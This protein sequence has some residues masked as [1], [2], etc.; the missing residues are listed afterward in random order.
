MLQEDG[1]K[2][3]RGVQAAGAT[4]LTEAATAAVEPTAAVYCERRAFATVRHRAHSGSDTIPRIL[5]GK[6]LLRTPFA[7]NCRAPPAVGT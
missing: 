5:S 6:H 2:L 4:L 7:S 1:D 3:L